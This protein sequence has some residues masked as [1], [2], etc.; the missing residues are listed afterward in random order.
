[1]VPCSEAPMSKHDPQSKK[2]PTDAESHDQENGEGQDQP[3]QVIELSEAAAELVSQLEAERDAA[4]AARQRALADYQNFQRRSIENERRA[5]EQ[6]A[7]RVVKSIMPVLDH[8]DLALGQNAKELSVEQLIGGV[9]IVRDELFKALQVNGVERIEPN[10]NDE[11]DPNRHE[12][13]MRQPSEGVAPNHIVCV[14]Q[15]GYAMGDQVLR[16]AKVAIAPEASD[17]A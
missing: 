15:A 10:Q 6:G 2:Q 1:M 13:M 12:A 17:Q 3:Q 9:K 7:T 16:P 4:V 8:F 11:F 5:G 14:M